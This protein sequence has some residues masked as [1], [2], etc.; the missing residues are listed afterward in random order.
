MHYPAKKVFKISRAI[1]RLKPEMLSAT[2]ILL[3]SN[4]KILVVEQGKYLKRE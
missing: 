4:V 2:G 1:V 3:V